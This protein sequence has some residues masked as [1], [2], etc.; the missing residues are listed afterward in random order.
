MNVCCVVPGLVCVNERAKGTRRHIYT[1]VHRQ[2]GVYLVLCVERK[3]CGVLRA[4]DYSI[5]NILDIHAENT[6]LHCA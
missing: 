3:N 2:V 5:G 1:Y 4:H 6:I